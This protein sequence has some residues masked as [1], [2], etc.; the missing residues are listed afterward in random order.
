MLALYAV[1]LA[2][3]WHAGCGKP[4]QE[5]VGEPGVPSVEEVGREPADDA[6][7]ELPRGF[8]QT[9]MVPKAGDDQYANPVVTRNG[10]LVDPQTGYAYEIWLKQP[11]MEFVL[12]P[13]GEFTRGSPATERDRDSKEAQHRVRLTK[14]FYLAKYEVT[15]GQWNAVAS[16]TPWSGKSHVRS[17]ARNPAVFVNW[18]D[19]QGFLK[20]LGEGFRLPTEAEWEYACRAGSTNRYCFGDSESQL[21]DYAWYDGNAW[22]IG[23]QYAHGVGQKRPNAWGFYDVHGNVWEWCSDWHGDYAMGSATDP[24]G[25]LRGSCRVYR[26]GSFFYGAGSSRSAL[27]FWCDPSYRYDFLGFRPVKALP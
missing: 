11:R 2:A 19:C 23:E 24:L 6:P 18:D 10:G 5:S 25:P 16:S 12:V 1:A 27:R 14:P 9:F 4:P 15:Q 3:S 20:G 26:G 7:A 13:A 22:D 8:H 17:E 21:G